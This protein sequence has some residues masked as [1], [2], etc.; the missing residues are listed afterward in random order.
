MKVIF[1]F[2]PEYKYWV[3]IPTL[4]FF[5]KG[6]TSEHGGKPKDYY[7]LTFAFI[8][9]GITLRWGDV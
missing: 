2:K 5:V 3:I 6:F 9:F 7:D 1:E 8:C 4:I